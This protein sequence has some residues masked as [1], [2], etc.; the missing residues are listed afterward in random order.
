[1][2]NKQ[3]LVGK[4][5]Y[6]RMVTAVTRRLMDLFPEDKLNWKPT[7][8]IRSA[9]EIISHHYGFLGAVVEGVATGKLP[10][11][12]EGGFASKAEM[13]KYM[14]SHLEKFYAGLDKLTDEQ[15][16]GKVE[17]WG[18]KFEGW[19]M[20][21]FAYDEHWHHRGQLTVY[22]RLLGIQPTMIYD[23]QHYNNSRFHHGVW[24]P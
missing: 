8:E 19:L 11:Y 13:F 14:D 5:G 24:T 1:M 23:Y 16:A 21:G 9:A 12:Q 2:M 18:E 22:L 15:I 10:N 7:P 6:F 17:A 3:Q 20:L 4:F